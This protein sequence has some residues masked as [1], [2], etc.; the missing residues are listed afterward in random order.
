ME[1]RKIAILGST[2]SMGVQALEVVEQFPE[3]LEIE[4]L[5]ALNSADLLIEQAKKFKPNTVVI[6]NET[7]Y[8][9]VK[10]ALWND[11]I[12]V[13]AGMDSLCDIMEMSSI[14]MV[15]SCIVGVAGLA[16]IYRAIENKK[17]IALA[18]KETLVVAGELMMK[19]ALEMNVPILPVDSEH[20]AIF[21]SLVGENLNPIE[22]LILTASG[23]PF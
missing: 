17:I 4:V 3:L 20:S 6:V 8:A 14:E 5:A 23:G 16:P 12:K 10:E 18:N 15:L 22:K 11:D 9:K 1:R 19:K 13:F 7:H 21:Q 2:G